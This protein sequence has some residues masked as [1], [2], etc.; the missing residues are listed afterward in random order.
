[1]KIFE[2]E[3]ETLE[4]DN[5]LFIATWTDSEDLTDEIF[6]EHLLGYR[7]LVKE[8]Q[9]KGLLVKNFNYGI[10]PETQVWVTKN[11]DKHTESI[12]KVAFLVSS[13]FYAQ[14]S[15]EQFVEESHS[16]IP[17]VRNRFF[18]NETEA[19]TWLL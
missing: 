7:D 13:E 16:N 2:S 12:K 3:Y 1:M 10:L 5:D 4:Y 8:Y 6:K 11:I 19:I 18:E 9:P 17:R 14:L 15:L